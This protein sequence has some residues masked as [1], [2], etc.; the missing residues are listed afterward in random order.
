MFENGGATPLLFCV[1]LCIVPSDM[2]LLRLQ[3]TL[4]QTNFVVFA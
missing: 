1:F 4:A 3:S 2:S